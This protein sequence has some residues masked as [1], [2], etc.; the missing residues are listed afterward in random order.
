[1]SSEA[2]Q[3][4]L[5]ER[6]VEGGA[7]FAEILL[8]GGGESRDHPDPGVVRLEPDANLSGREAG[9][10][11]EGEDLFREQTR[12]AGVVYGPGETFIVRVGEEAFRERGGAHDRHPGGAVVARVVA[13]PHGHRV[14]GQGGGEADRRVRGELVHAEAIETV[15]LGGLVGGGEALDAPVGRAVIT[16]LALGLR[17]LAD[18]EQ[19]CGGHAHVVAV[20]EVQVDAVGAERLERGF[21][22]G[23]EVGGRHAVG[24]R[25]EVVL[26]ALRADHELVAVA[27]AAEI[28]AE[29]AFAAVEFAGH[30]V[31]VDGR[32]IDEIAA[33]RGEQVEQ[34]HA[35]GFIRPEA[36]A[37]LPEADL[38][39]FQV[40]AVYPYA[41]HIAVSPRGQILH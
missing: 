22:V 13:V 12:R 2:E 25:R 5:G 17:L 36:E 26:A 35:L 1:M 40:R 8:C 15:F 24:L 10:L 19:G 29:D 27:A 18:F 3:G 37:Y 16:D 39:D 21:Q 38:R 30:P 34:A 11:R 9:L 4:V 20:E 41:V 23:H 33:E 28:V 31:R 32:G 7:E 6:F 14:V